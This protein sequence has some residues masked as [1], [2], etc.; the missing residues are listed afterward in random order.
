MSDI[1]QG[2][3]KAEEVAEA[4]TGVIDSLMNTFSTDASLL[5]NMTA[6]RQSSA[7]A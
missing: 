6:L 7:S 4:A 3:I 5:N 1:S 2:V